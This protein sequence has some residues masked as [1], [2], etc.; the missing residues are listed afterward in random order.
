MKKL[1]V[2]FALF[3]LSLGAKADNLPV[4]SMKDIEGCWERIVFSE[5]VKK[6]MNPVEPWPA[7]YQWFCFEADG[8]YSSVMS[9]QP[10]KTSATE[11]RQAFKALPKSFRYTVEP[12]GFIKTEALNGQETYYWASAFLGQDVNFDNKTLRKGT[13]IMSIPSE[14]GSTGIYWRYLNRVK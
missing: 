14:D 9:T 6:Q 4:Q 11:L 12:N 2:L 3:A 10:I 8:T 5:P 7:P 13:L 1:N